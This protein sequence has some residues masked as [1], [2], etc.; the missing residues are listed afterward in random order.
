MSNENQNQQSV[1]VI[2]AGPAGLFSARELGNAGLRVAV[3]VDG[4]L[5]DPTDEDRGWTVEIALPW[6]G[7]AAFMGGCAVT[8]FMPQIIGS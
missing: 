4:T 2:G 8:W 5:N 3:R 6:A 7:M 1:I